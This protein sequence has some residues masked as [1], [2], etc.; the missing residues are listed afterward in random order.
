MKEVFPKESDEGRQEVCYTTEITGY[1]SL[2]HKLSPIRTL[3]KLN[4][5]IAYKLSDDQH[6]TMI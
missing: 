1:Y 4:T 5:K 3:L 2:T 6:P